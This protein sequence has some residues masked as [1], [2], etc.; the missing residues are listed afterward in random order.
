MAG[1]GFAFMPEY[2]IILVEPSVARSVCLVHISCP[3]R[4]GVPAGGADPPVR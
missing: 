3:R 1:L 4:D 2:S